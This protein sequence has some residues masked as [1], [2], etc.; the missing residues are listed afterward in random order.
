MLNISDYPERDIMECNGLNENDPVGS[1]IWMLGSHL[2]VY[3][4]LGDMVLLEE[5]DHRDLGFQKST[6]DSVSLFSWRRVSDQ[7]IWFW[8]EPPSPHREDPK[9]APD[10]VYQSQLNAIFYKLPRPWC[11]ITEIKK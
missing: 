11:F 1:C 10:T 8:H 2:V 3:L 5:I 6:P 7:D 4:G 9:L